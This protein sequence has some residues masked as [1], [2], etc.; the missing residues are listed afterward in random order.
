[1]L[2]I[3]TQIPAPR[4]RERQSYPFMDMRVGDSFLIVD[5]DLVRNA[6]SAA[7]MFGKRHQGVRFS[8]RRVEG[9]WRLWRVA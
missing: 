9:G 7:W 3:D 2:T 8:C 5:E 4:V 1:M 6:R